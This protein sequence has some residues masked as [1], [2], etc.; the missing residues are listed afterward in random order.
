MPKYLYRGTYTASGANG[1]MREGGSGRSAAAAELIESVGGSMEA[2]YWTL[3]DDDFIVIADM[4]D[5]AAA[6]AAS[7]TVG[8]SGSLRVTTTPL[9]SAADVDEAAGRT[10]EYRPP[11]K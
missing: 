6:V 3:G 8:G 2:I 11:G 7:L 4:P 5:Q 9:M 1:V 10:V